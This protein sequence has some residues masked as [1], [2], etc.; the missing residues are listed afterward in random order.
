MV[1]STLDKDLIFLDEA[2]PD[3]TKVVHAI[4]RLRQNLVKEAKIVSDLRAK[5]AV[6]KLRVRSAESGVL[7]EALEKSLGRYSK[8]LRSASSSSSPSASSSTTAEPMI[9]SEN[10]L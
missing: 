4:R 3:D 6:S 5:D 1:H 8:R 9:D 2:F 7:A 10:I